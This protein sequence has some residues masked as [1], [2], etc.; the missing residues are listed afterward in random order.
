MKK[1]TVEFLSY[2]DK[3]KRKDDK[4]NQNPYINIADPQK[5]IKNQINPNEI[6]IPFNTI[7]I[8]YDYPMTNKVIKEFTSQN[9]NGFTRIEL[10]NKI[11]E[12]YKQI[13]DEEYKVVGDPGN[14]PGML[15][16]SRSNGPYGIYGHYIEDLDLLDVTQVNDNL[17]QL[18][19]DS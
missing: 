17:F 19:V 12:G 8:L 15:N 11:C 14:I 16:R 18:S 4:D 2:Y 5:S 3:R 10:A 7:K 9:K 13:Y 1:I 6:V